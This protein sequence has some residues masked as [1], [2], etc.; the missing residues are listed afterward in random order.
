MT[1]YE[2]WYG[3]SPQEASLEELKKVFYETEIH[4]MLE[5]WVVF[6]AMRE[7]ENRNFDFSLDE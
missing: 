1:V 5:N 2:R 4:G 3:H 6:Q 7:L